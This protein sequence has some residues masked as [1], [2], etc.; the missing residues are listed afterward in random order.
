MVGVYNSLKPPPFLFF[1]K[2]SKGALLFFQNSR[3]FFVKVKIICNLFN[4]Y[5]LKN[6]RKF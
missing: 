3:S 2:K 6:C 1:L 5:H 4:W